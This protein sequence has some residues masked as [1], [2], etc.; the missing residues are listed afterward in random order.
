MGDGIV[1]PGLGNGSSCAITPQRGAAK[2]SLA[3]L[4]R[5]LKVRMNMTCSTSSFEILEFGDVHYF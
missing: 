5:V 4:R 2:G 1:M 3:E